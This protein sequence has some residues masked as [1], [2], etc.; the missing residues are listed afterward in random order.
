MKQ[1]NMLVNSKKFQVLFL[2]RKKELI[3]SDMSL[4]INSNN[5]F[6]S[7]GVKLLGIKIDSRRNFEL[8]VSDLYKSAARQLNALLRLK[9]YLTFEARK[10]LAESF[11]S[12]NE[13]LTT[14][15]YWSVW[16]NVWVFVYELS[17][18]GFES[19]CCHLNFRYGACFEQRVPWHSGKLWSAVSLWNVC[20]TW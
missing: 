6:S 11:V 8:H 9:S 18:C 3:T 12:C 7:N 14:A 2:S 1:N 10:I 19:R 5:I 13:I 20:V 4:N 15:L 17:A 16:L